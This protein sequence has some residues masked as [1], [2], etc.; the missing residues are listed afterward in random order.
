M[1]SV[2]YIIECICSSLLAYEQIALLHRI[3]VH[4]SN[5]RMPPSTDVSIYAGLEPMAAPVFVTP[6]EVEVL[7]PEGEPPEPVCWFL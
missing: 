7:V 5:Q 4:N 2:P 3:P 1:Y 6:A